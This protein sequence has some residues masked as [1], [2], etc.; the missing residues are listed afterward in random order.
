M[1]G[2]LNDVYLTASRN[3]HEH[4]LNEIIQL[5]NREQELFAQL[6][7]ATSVTSNVGNYDDVIA[8]M[9]ELSAIRTNLFASLGNMYQYTENNVANSRIDLVDQLTLAKLVE[10]QLNHA[11]TDLNE[12]QKIKDNKMRLVE[13]DTYYGK[14]YNAMGE[15]MKLV[16]FIAVPLVLLMFIKQ[17]GLL[18]DMVTKLVS[19]VIMAGGIF[20]IIR[21]AWDIY[22]RSDMNFDEYDWKYSDPNTQHPT[23]MEY[24]RKNFVNVDMGLRDII[25]NLNIGCVGEFCCSNGM[26]Y[27]ETSKR[28]VLL[29]AEGSDVGNS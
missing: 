3:N 29:N 5:Q 27:N 16:I 15:M 11:K 14:R 17:R 24:N 9:N 4:I 2:E 12:L 25:S 23:I 1:S 20:L 19:G 21:K 6:T 8:Q 10:D 26:Y 18:P 28:C 7:T 22:T 13:I